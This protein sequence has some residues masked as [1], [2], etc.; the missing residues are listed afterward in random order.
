MEFVPNHTGNVGT[1][2]RPYL[3]V[4]RVYLSGRAEPTQNVGHQYG[5]HTE[6]TGLLGTGIMS[7]PNLLAVPGTGIEPVANLTAV[8]GT[9]IEAVPKTCYSYKMHAH[10]SLTNYVINSSSKQTAIATSE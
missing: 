1:V 6:L 5:V 3:I 2:L 9:G 10:E 8:L 4:A 7:V